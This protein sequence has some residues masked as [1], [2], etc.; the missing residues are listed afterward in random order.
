MHYG[1]RATQQ[2]AP[3]RIYLWNKAGTMT[4][5]QNE[6]GRKVDVSAVMYFPGQGSA[7]RLQRN[8]GSGKEIKECTW[9]QVWI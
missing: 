8:K 2:A 6:L 1:C 7:G 5:K 9:L 3:A 4:S